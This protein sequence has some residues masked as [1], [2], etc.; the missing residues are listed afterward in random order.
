MKPNDKFNVR[1][2]IR[3]D[4]VNGYSIE[5]TVAEAFRSGFRYAQGGYKYIYNKQ[6]REIVLEDD[7][8]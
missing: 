4:K 6:T 1:E 8:E 7:G 5:H 3:D 2:I